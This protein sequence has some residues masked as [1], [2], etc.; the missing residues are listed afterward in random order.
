MTVDAG[1]SGRVVRARL[2]HVVRE[3][4][5]ARDWRARLVMWIALAG[6]LAAPLGWVPAL[7]A[8]AFLFIAWVNIRFRAKR[9]PVGKRE[10]ENEVEV[11]VERDATLGADGLALDGRFVARSAIAKIAVR[12]DACIIE[13]T[14]G[15]Q[16]E[17]RGTPLDLA[18][19]ARIASDESAL[20]RDETG[21]ALLAR[22]DVA[23]ARRSQNDYRGMS[24]DA[25]R[26]LAIAEDPRADPR[27]RVA[28]A[29]LIGDRLDE[30]A[31][32]RI[33]EAAEEAANPEVS[34]ALAACAHRLRG[35]DR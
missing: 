32:V 16:I 25:E 31:R 29:E 18:R 6:L 13:T 3:K 35:E 7:T 9:A 30:P 20:P 15:E 5:R 4:H 14:S 17:L 33:A 19:A 10:A 11:E 28:A 2:R 26:C 22:I 23:S 8:L 24:L 21:E 12:G 34:E 1:G 27:A